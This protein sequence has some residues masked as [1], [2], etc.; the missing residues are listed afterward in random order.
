MHKSWLSLKQGHEMSDFI[1]TSDPV[2]KE[3]GSESGMYWVEIA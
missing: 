3:D 2:L 1:M